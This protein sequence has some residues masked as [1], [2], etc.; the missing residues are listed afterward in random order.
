MERWAT[1]KRLHQSALERTAGQRAAFLDVA[2]AGDEALRRDVE[3]LLA[4]DT[5]AEPF[6]ELP[7]LEAGRRWHRRDVPGPRPPP[8]PDGGGQGPAPRS[9]RRCRPSAALCPG[10]QGHIQEAKATSALNHPN[11]ATIYDVGESD[12]VRFMV[13]EYVEGLTLAEKLAAPRGAAVTA[14]VPLRVVRAAIR[15][16]ARGESV[17]ILA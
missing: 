3:S 1:I 14:I 10:S 5:A 8:G 11:V 12:G 15:T 4:Q 2:C 13:M 7:A 16:V 17:R 9:L 6:L